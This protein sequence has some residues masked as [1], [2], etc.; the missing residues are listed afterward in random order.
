MSLA[1]RGLLGII[2]N[3][4]AFAIS[5]GS[6][7][8]PEALANSLRQRA[9]GLASALQTCLIASLCAA[10][11]GVVILRYYDV[12]PMLATFAMVTVP[13]LALG[14]IGRTLCSATGLYRRP[15]R[16]SAMTGLSRSSLLLALMPGGI[17]LLSSI[18]AYQ[19]TAAIVTITDYFRPIRD[20]WVAEHKDASLNYRPRVNM[21][22]IGF[23][24]LPFIIF[25]AVLL[26][27]DL[28][29]LGRVGTANDVGVYAAMSGI[30]TS[31]LSISGAFRTRIIGAAVSEAVATLKRELRILI[32]VAS[33][34]ALSGALLAP[35]IVRFFLGA[36]YTAQTQVFRV[37]SISSGLL[38]LLDS[39]QA[40]QAAYGRRKS[41]VSGAVLGACASIVAIAVLTP[42][43]HATGAALG[44]VLGLSVPVVLSFVGL[45]HQLVSG[46]RHTSKSRG[47]DVK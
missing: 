20:Q 23:Q 12:S 32:A 37:L 41:L 35:L 33:I 39:G 31:S 17:S 1:D 42:H 8:Q 10:I 14:N 26:K 3:V 4:A 6:F 43:L 34:T 13:I 16:N 18:F 38:L 21:T 46:I 29:I 5:L 19:W 30:T 27:G 7:G 9:L 45:R 36:Q 47:D 11:S 28:L 44:N 22:R 2:T 24:L 25:T 40:L 15:S